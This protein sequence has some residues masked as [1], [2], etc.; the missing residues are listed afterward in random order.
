MINRKWI[1]H[2]FPPYTRKIEASQLWFFAKA[3]GETNP[4]YTDEKAAK[5]AGYA[6]LPAPP[7]FGF[8]LSNAQADTFDY[9]SEMGIDIAVVLHGEEN[10]EYIQPILVGDEITFQRRV[11][12]IYE[13]KGGLL[14][15]VKMET[16]MTNQNE[17]LVGKLQ[18]T[19]VVRY[20]LK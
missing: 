16:S 5:A 8:S 12:D 3:I 10:F 19:F 11:L 1:G 6:A 4:I 14:E 18:T 20:D 9:L 2:T 15:M 7:T 17:Q 13:K